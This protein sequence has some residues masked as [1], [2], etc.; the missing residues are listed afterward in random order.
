MDYSPPGSSVQQI[1]QAR[2]L[3]WVAIS[4][5]R[6]LRIHQTKRKSNLLNGRAYMQIIYLRDEYPKFVKNSW[7]N[8]KKK[9]QSEKQKN[10]TTPN[11]KFLRSACVLSHFSCVRLFATLQTAAHQASP[12]MRSSGKNTGMA[13]HFLLQGI[14][15]TQESTCMSGLLHWQASSLP[16]VPPG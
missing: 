13:C 10:K 2:L 9:S 6:K 3:E 7:F 14:F 5:S 15:L 11:L 1:S 16:L 8:R 12:S 4:F